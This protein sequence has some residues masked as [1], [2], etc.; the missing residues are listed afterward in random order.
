MLT[1]EFRRIKKTEEFL[2]IYPGKKKWPITYKMAT[3]VRTDGR[4][5]GFVQRPRLAAGKKLKYYCRNARICQ[6]DCANN[7]HVIAVLIVGSRPGFIRKKWRAST[8]LSR[9]TFRKYG[10]NGVSV[11]E[12]DRKSA[13]VRRHCVVIGTPAFFFT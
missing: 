6:E 4:M 10:K 8:S 12:I 9:E 7:G 3:N 11:R 1:I 2:E 13:I 5:D